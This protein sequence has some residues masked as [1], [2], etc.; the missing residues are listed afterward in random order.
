MSALGFLQP[1]AL[2][3]FAPFSS[4]RPSSPRFFPPPPPLAAFPIEP[5]PLLTRKVFAFPSASIS[6]ARVACRR[7]FDS[8]PIGSVGN[9]FLGS[10]ASISNFHLLRPFFP[11]LPVFPRDIHNARSHNIFSGM[12]IRGS[13]L[14]WIRFPS[15]PSSRGRC[16]FLLSLGLS[17]SS[18]SSWLVA[19]VVMEHKGT[20][21]R[22]RISEFLLPQMYPLLFLHVVHYLICQRIGAQKPKQS[23][24]L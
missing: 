9:G 7:A 10:V 6:P 2:F 17:S 20:A 19:L 3:S 12:L 16:R 22:R 21:H 13:P 4:R 23:F 15:N 8:L 24:S 18:D 11:L 5:S 14:L 1:G